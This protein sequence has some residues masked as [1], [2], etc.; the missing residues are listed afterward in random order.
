MASY[1]GDFFGGWQNDI[2]SLIAIDTG[3]KKLN[4]AKID[5]L[6]KRYEEAK[7]YGLTGTTIDDYISKNSGT[8]VMAYTDKVS[9]AVARS[10]RMNIEEYQSLEEQR[11]RLKAKKKTEEKWPWYNYAI[12]GGVIIAVVALSP[13]LN[14]FARLIPTK[15]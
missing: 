12:A 6:N 13:T 2:A 9:P 8:A 5:L 10:F 14:T 7:G 1:G 11:L 3:T 4:N 15:K